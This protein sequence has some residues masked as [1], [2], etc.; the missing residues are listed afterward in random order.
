MCTGMGTWK[1]SEK[2]LLGICWPVLVIS[3]YEA[4]TYLRAKTKVLKISTFFSESFS[5]NTELSEK[6]TAPVPFFFFF[7]VLPCLDS[8]A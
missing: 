1:D 5:G 8:L 3:V 7:L 2:R 6:L 4:H